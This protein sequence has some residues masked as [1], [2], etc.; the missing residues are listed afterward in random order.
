MEGL[1]YLEPCASFRLIFAPAF[2]LQ[3][4]HEK[5]ELRICIS[6]LG[7]LSEQFSWTNDNEKKS[8]GK[9]GR[10]KRDE[11]KLTSYLEILSDSTTKIV[12]VSKNEY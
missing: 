10:G 1:Y 5:V 3:I 12:H 2:A 4:H 9:L 7:C 11:V 6:M 8:V